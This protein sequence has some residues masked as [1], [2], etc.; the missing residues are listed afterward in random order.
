MILKK[1]L[2]G[3]FGF[4]GFFASAQNG[5]STLGQKP[6]TAFPV[7]GTS[8]FK[9]GIVPNCAGASIPVPACAAGSGGYTDVRPFWYKFTCF[10]TGT[11][12]FVIKPVSTTDDYDWQVFDVTNHNAT[13][14]YT[15]SSLFV[16]CNWS[17][18]PG[19]TGTSTSGTIANGCAGPTYSNIS[20]MPTLQQGH[21]YLL[22]VSNFSPSQLGYELSFGGGTASITDTLQPKFL[23]A[24][25]PC[26][27]TK[28]GIK[29]NKKM[30]CNTIAVDGSDFSINTSITKVIGAVGNNCNSSFDL[31]SISLTLS[32]PLPPGNY[33]LSAKNG[34]DGNT[35]LDICST[36]IPVGESVGVTVYPVVATP[37]D[38][39]TKVA[40]APQDLA[41]VFNKFM[42]CSSIAADGS[43]FIVTGPTAVT[44]LKASG[45]CNADGLTKTITV[46]LLKPIQTAGN[47][48]IMLKKGIDGNTI[49]NDCGKETPAGSSILFTT[50]DTVSAAFTYNIGYG[51]LRDTI[52]FLHNGRNGVNQWAWDFGDG[53]ISSLQNNLNL[54]FPNTGTQNV[55]LK[56]SNGVCT[57]SITNS[58][59]LAY[60]TLK[61][62]FEIPEFGCPNE[63]L[64]LTNK[65][66]GKITNYDWDFGNG[67]KSTVQNPPN[68][69]YPSPV[70]L[71]KKYTI[72]LTVRNAIGCSNISL[73]D[74]TVLKSCYIAVPTAF[75]PNGD[76]LNDFLYPLNAY[77]ADNLLFRVYNR[78]GNLVFET[79]DWTKKWDGRINGI[80][81]PSGTYVWQLNYVDTDTRQSFSEKGTTVL[82]R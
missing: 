53:R 10:Q 80:L 12:G 4:I 39:L 25:S 6:E 44:V 61:A 9:Q 63:I 58:I 79:T 66:T 57:D 70:T 82:I 54:Y 49:L 24:L 23:R 22:L 26:D 21:E 32:N 67:T 40:C 19:A 3:L 71:Q 74:V 2:C 37:M 34:S 72:R 27:G 78:Y 14:V 48:T 17:S 76:G 16:S 33:I 59:L 1:I 64:I 81:Q 77:K 51:C 11:L 8:I 41:L 60:D 68:F 28:M 42:I 55:Q 56:V 73:H 20:S 38:S 31:D 36:P 52:S 29:L 50:V 43:D 46:S 13:D 45:I 69:S 7:C 5:C 15:N 75:T 18:N 47:Y 30:K 62:I 65:S 35:L